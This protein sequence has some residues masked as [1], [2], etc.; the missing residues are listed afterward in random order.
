MKNLGV[1]FISMILAASG[2]MAQG[3]WNIDPSHTNIG[4]AIDHMVISEVTGK[5]N[6]FEGKLKANG[7]AIEG[8]QISFSANVGSIDTENEKRDAHLK[9]PDFFD[10][11]NHPKITFKSTS[12]TKTGD[13]TYTVKGDLT[14]RGTTK[15]VELA[16]KHNGTVKDP[17]GNTRA[18]FKLSGEINRMDYGLKWN[19][20]L[21][22]GG[23]VVGEEVR[24]ICNIEVIKTG[25]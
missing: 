16:L 25:S 10:A 5:F 19:S 4:F 11:A 20:A 18:G 6:T 23:L 21:E 7:E 24:I 12:V 9:S 13:K 1:L 17:Y 14:I 22:T 3:T 15:E 8:S 2:M